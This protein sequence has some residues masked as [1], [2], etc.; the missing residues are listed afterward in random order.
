MCRP[1]SIAAIGGI[2]KLARTCYTGTGQRSGRGRAQK[3][4]RNPTKPS[5][6]PQGTKRHEQT[7]VAQHKRQQ[8]RQDGGN[9]HEFI[10]KRTERTCGTL[11]HDFLPPFV[12]VMDYAR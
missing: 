12:T 11:G 6:Q 10:F 3:P 8:E 2:N 5:D 9:H 1:F 4:E 7:A